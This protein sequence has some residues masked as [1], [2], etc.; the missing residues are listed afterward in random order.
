[1]VE[2]RPHGATMEGD[3]Q[4]GTGN[5]GILLLKKENDLCELYCALLLSSLADTFKEAP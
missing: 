4:L 2:S 5:M 1:M 3:L